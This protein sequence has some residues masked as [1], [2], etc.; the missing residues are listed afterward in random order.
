MTIRIDGLEKRYGSV[1]ALRGIDL[2]IPGGGIVG[3]LG[4]NGAGKTT[5]VE[6][7]EGLRDPTRGSVSVLG[8]DPTTQA[9]RLKE[10][11]GVQLQSTSIPLDLTPAS[12]REDGCARSW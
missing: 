2:E 1:V 12:C 5:L 4:P 10:R 8:L 6:I 3:L 7:L 9:R 11:I